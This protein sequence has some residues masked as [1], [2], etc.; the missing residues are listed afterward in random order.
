MLSDRFP[1]AIIH[2]FEPH[3][4]TFSTLTPNVPE[5]VTCHNLAVGDQQGSFSLFD[6]N[7]RD[8][9]PHASLHKDVITQFHKQSYVE[10]KVQATTLDSF[11]ETKNIPRIDFLKIDTEGHEYAVL[12]GA[13]NLIASGR[14]SVIQFEFG[15][16]HLSSHI[17]LDDI[18]KL[19][20][21]Y[22]LFRILPKKLLLLTGE[23]IEKELFAF[24]NIL[25]IPTAK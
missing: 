11:C 13:K 9:S 22:S 10:H 24:Q 4:K 23:P 18:R 1:S 3:P 8:G 12:Q 25:A 16:P 15:A 2:A 21:E 6:R 7:D 20:K 14:I 5:N 17:F 19:L